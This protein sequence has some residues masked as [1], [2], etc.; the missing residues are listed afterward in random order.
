MIACAQVSALAPASRLA[1]ILPGRLYKA[2]SV[3][4]ARSNGRIFHHQDAPFLWLVW[5]ELMTRERSMPLTSTPTGE[6]MAEP[7]KNPLD[8]LD[9]WLSSW[10]ASFDQL[11]QRVGMPVAVLLLLLVG[12][13]TV[14][15]NWEDI[16]K[17]GVESLITHFEYRSEK[18]DYHADQLVADARQSVT[19]LKFDEARAAYGKALTLYKQDDNRLGQANVLRGVGDLEAS[20]GHLDKARAA[21]DEAL[22][23]YRAI[24]SS[25]GEDYVLQ[26]ITNLIRQP[27]QRGS[28]R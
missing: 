18:R 27:L 14:W 15:W 8:K 5:L 10:K 21:Y 23:L 26:R 2:R 3:V 25:Q 11:R 17:P 9:D 4:I 22:P 13:G 19:V 1:L 6:W 16:K 20:L 24:Q 28:R 12:G 7:K